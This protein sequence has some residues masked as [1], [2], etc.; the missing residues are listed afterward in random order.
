MKK[1]TLVF[2]LT[3]LLSIASQAQEKTDSTKQKRQRK[4]YLFGS[5]C[6]SFTKAAVEKPFITV[7]NED[8]TVVDTITASTYKD[9]GS[10][11]NR[12]DFRIKVP[13]VATK[14]IIR[15]Q[16]PEY[17]DLYLDY[18]IKYVA[19]N[20]YF[21]LPMLEM[22]KRYAYDKELDEVEVVATKV[23]MVINTIGHLLGAGICAFV[24]A[25]GIVQMQKFLATHAKS[26][27]TGVGFPT[28]PFALIFSIGFFD[29]RSS[30]LRKE[31]NDLRY[32]SSVFMKLLEILSWVSLCAM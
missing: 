10:Q 16:A 12:T 22:Q 2:F 32:L 20:A 23:Q 3:M 27:T 14:Y 19:R 18:E 17:E 29:I 21:N 15:A 8:S 4:V 28:W 7:M 6:D 30:L 25:R 13:A 26:S 31:K 11:M 24:G 5:V 9:W 1:L